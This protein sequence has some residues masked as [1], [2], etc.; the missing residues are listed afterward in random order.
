MVGFRISDEMERRTASRRIG[1]VTVNALE[2]NLQK[3][4]SEVSRKT[5]CEEMVTY[6]S[7]SWIF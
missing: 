1:L 5:S 6:I 4:I 7:A 2:G 3:S